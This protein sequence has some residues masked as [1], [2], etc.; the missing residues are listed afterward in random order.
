MYNLVKQ[1]PYWATLFDGWNVNSLDLPPTL[2]YII[3]IISQL[4]MNGESQRDGLHY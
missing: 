1:R 2:W 3:D 4:V